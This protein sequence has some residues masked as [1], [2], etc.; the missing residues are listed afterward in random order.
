MT[1]RNRR[2]NVDIR[3][4]IRTKLRAEYN[5]LAMGI[6]ARVIKQEQTLDKGITFNDNNISYRRCC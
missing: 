6:A 2:R 3:E 4:D 5:R 1:L